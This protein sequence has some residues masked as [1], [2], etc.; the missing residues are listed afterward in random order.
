MKQLQRAGSVFISAALFSSM[1]FSHLPEKDA[2]LST[3]SVTPLNW[4]GFYAGLNIGGVKN[5][6]NLT[7]VQA[8]TFN[9]TIEQVTNPQFSGG[10]QLG[11]RRQ[12][13][14]TKTSGVYGVEFSADFSNAS[15]SK[16]Y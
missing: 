15:V 5:T 9:A 11:V 1:A 3:I 8:T 12:S 6:M 2:A 14:S 13:D 7:D 10:F 16:Q 4:T